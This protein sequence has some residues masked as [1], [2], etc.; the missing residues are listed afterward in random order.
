MKN[1]P[2]FLVS[3]RGDHARRE[4]L[5]A[6]FPGLFPAMILVEAVDGRSL[7]A[8]DYFRFASSAMANHGRILAP[9]EVGCSLS[10]IKA[11]EQF[12]ETGAERAVI[13]EDDVIGNDD[14]LT[15]AIGDLATIPE[16][17]LIIFGG[18][19]GLPSRKYIFGKPV[20][21]RRVFKLPRYSHHH[22]LRTCCY[23]VTRTSA[24]NILASQ[25]KSLKL[26]DAWG[27]L[28]AG[29]ENTIIH[30]SSRLAHPV[31]RNESHIEH[32]RAGVSSGAEKGVLKFLIKRSTRLKRKAGAVWCRLNGY[33]RIA[34]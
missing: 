24:A 7:N 26:A 22:V 32:S 12:L 34:R 3:M 18:Q 31:D 4:R 13:L 19:E 9:A 1:I 11:L 2:I 16:A 33:R 17:S 6:A 14:A 23:G 10:H 21:E 27:R 30:F 29:H 20:G 25:G 15:E 5:S 28:F 8:Q